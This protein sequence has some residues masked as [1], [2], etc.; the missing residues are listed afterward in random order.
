MFLIGLHFRVR[1]GAITGIGGRVGMFRRALRHARGGLAV[2]GL[3]DLLAGGG[4]VDEVAAVGEALDGGVPVGD[5]GSGGGV[6]LGEITGRVEG[7]RRVGRELCEHGRAGGDGV[8]VGAIQPLAQRGDVL[9]R[10]A[11]R[12]EFLIGERTEGV[13]AFRERRLNTMPIV[14]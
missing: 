11:E 14:R 9:R 12:G 3:A 4:V 10:H 7:V 8:E 1:G 6:G 2:G 13:G 5:G